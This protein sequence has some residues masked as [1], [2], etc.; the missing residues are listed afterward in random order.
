MLMLIFYLY[1]FI[2]AE[3]K[4]NLKLKL[5]LLLHKVE[6]KCNSV[7]QAIHQ[8]IGLTGNSEL[9][10]KMRIKGRK[11]RISQKLEHPNTHEH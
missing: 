5:K 4:W 6:L 3:T 7:I 2:E 11:I 1:E 8:W 9:N 10:A